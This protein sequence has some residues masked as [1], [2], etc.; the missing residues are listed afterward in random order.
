MKKLETMPG[1]QPGFVQKQCQGFRRGLPLANSPRAK[2]MAC[3]FAMSYFTGVFAPRITPGN[4]HETRGYA[5]FARGSA[6]GKIPD[7]L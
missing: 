3:P 6:P 2:A 1:V 4:V 7:F 5:L